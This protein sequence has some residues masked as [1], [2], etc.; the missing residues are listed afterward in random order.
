MNNPFVITGSISEKYF[1][2][3][4]EESKKV[5]RTLSNW[6]NLCLISPRLW[7]NQS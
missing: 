2:D 4:R 5:I 1:C 6:G 3:R 7:G